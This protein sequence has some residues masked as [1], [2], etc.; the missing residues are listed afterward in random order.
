MSKNIRVLDHD[1]HFRSL[2]FPPIILND[3]PARTKEEREALN[4][5]IMT[6][7]DNTDTL[8]SVP[9]C[10][11][12]ALSYGH[13]LGAMC[14]SCGTRVETPTD[15]KIEATVWI[16]SPEGIVSLVNPVL[17]LVLGKILTKS[18]YNVLYWFCNPYAEDPP[19]NN[20]AAIQLIRRFLNSG[21]PRGLNSFIVNFDQLVPIFLAAVPL[22]SNRPHLESFISENKDKFFPQHLPVPSKVAFVLEKTSTGSYADINIRDPINACLT[23]TSLDSGT[24]SNVKRLESRMSSVINDLSNY[25]KHM[26]GDPFSAKAGLLRKTVFGSRMGYSFR[27]V[28]TS[29]HGVHDYEQIKIPYSQAVT[30]LKAHL[31]NKLHKLEYNERDAKAY[32][33]QHT[34]ERD[35]LLL[36]LLYELIAEAPG[37]KGIRCL[38]IRY[39]TLTRGS[40]QSLHISD[41]S[42]MSASLSIL[43]LNGATADEAA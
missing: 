29:A 38:W 34:K 32:I 12:G 8:E 37:G 19:H 43:A 17:W 18:H 28:I 9:S 22:A 2:N 40:I 4:N 26:F 14:S 42:E 5:I 27:C 11:C 7:Y 3:I 31:L 24:L 25:Y 21:I 15:R 16:R 36:R 39:P 41:I 35:P 10:A 6:T 23:V 33:A 13:N 1:E 20:K 30:L